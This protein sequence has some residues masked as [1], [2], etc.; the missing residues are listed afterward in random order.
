[1]RA[2]KEMFKGVVNDISNLMGEQLYLVPCSYWMYLSPVNSG[3]ECQSN[4]YLCLDNSFSNANYDKLMAFEK[5]IQAAF[6]RMQKR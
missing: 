4:Y 5:G 3:L 6:R 2:T 1:M